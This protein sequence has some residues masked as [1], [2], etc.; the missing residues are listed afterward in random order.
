M[1]LKK[2]RSSENAKNYIY[3]VE[4]FIDKNLIFPQVLK[5]DTILIENPFEFSLQVFWI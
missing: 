2:G 3:A 1:E 5:N 4:D